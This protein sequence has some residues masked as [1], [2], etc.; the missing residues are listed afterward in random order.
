MKSPPMLLSQCRARSRLEALE[1]DRS[2]L[3]DNFRARS[4]TGP[5]R[6]ETATQ[7]VEMVRFAEGIGSH[8]VIAAN[9][10]GPDVPARPRQD[11]A[12]N[13]LKSFDRRRIARQKNCLALAR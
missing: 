2:S 12:S 5:R 1:H 3:S 4:P 6:T 11:S 13:T 10:A 7:P 8:Q 9:A